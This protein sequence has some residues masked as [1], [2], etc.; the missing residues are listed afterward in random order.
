MFVVLD[1]SIICQD[2][3]FS[4][5]ASRVLIGNYR[6]LPVTLAVPEV[7]IDEVTNK[8]RERLTVAC[9]A[10]E[11]AHKK[12]K[13][14]VPEAASLRT[15]PLVDQESTR[16]REFLSELISSVGGRTLPYPE[17]P[18]QTI[19]K[20]ELQ[21][22]KPSKEN[23]SGYRDLLIWE[24][25]RRLTWSGHERIAFITANVRDFIADARLHKDL[26]ADILN[27][28]RVEVF[29]SL[30]DFNEK[31]LVPRLETDDRFNKELQ[32]VS[33]SS[34]NVSEWIRENLLE[35]LR[36]D[37]LG[38]A[39]S[40]VPDV[41]SFHASEIV[42]FDDFKVT[43]ARKLDDGGRL[44]SVMVQASVDVSIDID[45]EDYRNHEEIRDSLGGPGSWHEIFPLAV[46]LELIID[47]TG[48]CVSSYEVTT[49]EVA[50]SELRIEV[51]DKAVSADA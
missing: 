12:L 27:P 4:G 7:V 51:P 11:D 20:R 28:G 43:S 49:V 47:P 32:T 22:R 40:P 1:S 9:R 39:I 26:A 38:Y 24:S 21:R 25:L 33:S 44:C 35:I 42:T 29:A 10:V 41:G 13:L 5:N 14:L 34:A 15:L 6:A 45:E 36:W 48:S 2:L 3:R 17:I 30:K 31:H 46:S 50:E 19:V 23:G 16:Y 8:F 18:H 37:E